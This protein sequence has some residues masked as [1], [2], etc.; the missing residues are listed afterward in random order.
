M[1]HITILIAVLMITP[2]AVDGISDLV[3]GWF[4]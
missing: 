4:S 3:K 1:H 2:F